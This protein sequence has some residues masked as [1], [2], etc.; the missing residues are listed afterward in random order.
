[1]S[2]IIDADLFVRDI[3]TWAEQFEFRSLGIG[4]PAFE[5]LIDLLDKQPTIEM[6]DVPEKDPDFGTWIDVNLG[7]PNPEDKKYKLVKRRGGISVARFKD[8]QWFAIQSKRLLK[9]VTHWMAIP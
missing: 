4:S 6:P 5:E 9:T 2:R 1:M 8:G 7:L 3:Y